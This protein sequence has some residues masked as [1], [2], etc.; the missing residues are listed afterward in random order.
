MK[1]NQLSLSSLQ[2]IKT[3]KELMA[4]LKKDSYFFV[5]YYSHYKKNGDYYI[6]I[7]NGI[8]IF[9]Y[10]NVEKKG[11]ELFPE[12]IR[13]INVEDL[14][15]LEAIVSWVEAR[16]KES[17]K[18]ITNTAVSTQPLLTNSEWEKIKNGPIITDEELSH[19][20]FEDQKSIVHY[21]TEKR[22][23][24]VY[25]LLEEGQY[26]MEFEEVLIE[27]GWEQYKISTYKK[28]T[29]KER[30]DVE[31]AVKYYEDILKKC[32]FVLQR[33]SLRKLLKPTT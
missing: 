10:G 14:D 17:E 26:M 20:L 8:A 33:Q 32:A 12:G 18:I 23:G 7:Q 9:P 28:V 15:H 3:E 25:M 22:Y 29:E 1:K 5:P 4:T 19:Y 31:C 21:P 11:K 6:Y 27:K 13:M 2:N 16:K 30:C 24:S